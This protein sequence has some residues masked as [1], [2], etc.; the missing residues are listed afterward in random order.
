MQSINPENLWL[1]IEESFRK[2]GYNKE[3]TFNNI[4]SQMLDNLNDDEMDKEQL[5]TLSLE[6]LEVQSSFIQ[7]SNKSNLTEILNQYNHQ[8]EDETIQIFQEL[9][10][11]NKIYL[12]HINLFLLMVSL[13]KESLSI[14]E[15]LENE[16]VHIRGI[17]KTKHPIVKDAIKPK[18]K[19]FRDSL[20][21]NNIEANKI[22]LNI[23]KEFENDSLGLTLALQLFDSNLMPQ[24]DKS[25]IDTLKNQKEFLNSNEKIE[26]YHIFKSIQLYA[27]QLVKNTHFTDNQITQYVNTIINDIFKDTVFE[28]NFTNSHIKKTIQYKC[29]FYALPLLEF[30]T[31]T[32][33]KTFPLFN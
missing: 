28:S 32:N 24:M 29:Q 12:Y 2:N 23:Y 27:I 10:S 8:F 20:E 31:A 6:I 5:K 9:I 16:S 22:G 3:E 19:Y 18:M 25:T 21:N 13:H 1:E 26:D 11:L 7:S 33:K 15:Q 14:L 4:I 30:Q 17:A